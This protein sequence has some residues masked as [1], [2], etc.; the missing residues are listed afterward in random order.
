MTQTYSYRAV[1]A[2]QT[3]TAI[4]KREGIITLTR[5]GGAT[6]EIKNGALWVYPDTQNRYEVGPQTAPHWLAEYRFQCLMSGK[7]TNF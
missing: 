2:L 6:L 5:N 3:L 7:D 1:Q 4:V